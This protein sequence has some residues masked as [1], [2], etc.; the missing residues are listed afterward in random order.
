MRPFIVVAALALTAAV[1]VPRHVMQ[2]Q[3]ASPAMAARSEAPARPAYS[4][5]RSVVVA[6]D[7]RGHFQVEGR[8]DNRFMEFMVDTGASAVA[9]TARDAA[10]VGLHPADSE[11]TITVRTANGVVRAAPVKLNT[12]EIGGIMVR[13]VQAM[14]LPEHA[15]SDNLLGLSFL[16]RL[17]RFEFS[18]GKLVLE[19]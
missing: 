12:V 3:K 14:V 15:L 18:G 4:D 17:H 10:A 2:S 9:L 7:G 11:F 5:S 16:S 8:V 13:D 6:P 19:Q 1:L